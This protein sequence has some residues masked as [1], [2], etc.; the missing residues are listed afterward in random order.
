MEKKL[1]D[2]LYFISGGDLRKA[3]NVLQMSVALD[4]LN[5]MDVNEILKISGFLDENILNE[6]IDQ[7][8]NNKFKQV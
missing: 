2:T 4:L 3:I 5:K 8:Q 7:I 6:L 1:Y